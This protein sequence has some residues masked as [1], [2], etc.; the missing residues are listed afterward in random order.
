MRAEE[1]LQQIKKLEAMI[2]NKTAEMKRWMAI[3]QSCGNFSDSERVQTTGN[4]SKMSDAI[5]TYLDIE[6]EIAQ[7]KAER[8]AI[9][10]TIESLPTLEY[11]VLHKIYVQ[12]W[13]LTDIADFYDK[14][15]SW[16]TKIKSRA[17]NLLQAILDGK[18]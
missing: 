15:Y 7:L 4:P 8:K 12:E 6:S 3:A 1:Y 14:S 9:I 16:A 5:S 17:L 2:K 11:D 10:T 18:C 13:S